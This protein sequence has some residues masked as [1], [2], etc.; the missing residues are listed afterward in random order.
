MRGLGGRIT[1]VSDL[2]AFAYDVKKL[3]V[4]HDAVVFALLKVRRRKRP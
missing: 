3:I 4:E 2:D 1:T